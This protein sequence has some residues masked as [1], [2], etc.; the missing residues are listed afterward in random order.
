MAEFSYKIEK[1]LG[2]LSENKEYTKRITL[3]AWN[4]REPKVDIRDWSCFEDE[5]SRKAMKGITLTK[6]EA[7]KLRDIL[8]EMELEG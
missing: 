4:N 6:D 8:N 5:A 1:D 2:I 7:K 3:T